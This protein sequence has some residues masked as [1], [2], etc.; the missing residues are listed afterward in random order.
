MRKSLVL[1][2]SLIL[3]VFLLATFVACTDNTPNRFTLELVDKDV[4]YFEFTLGEIDWDQI[5]FYIYDNE[6]NEIYAQHTATE[7]MVAEEDRDKLYFA[8]TKTIKLIYQGAELFVTL[9]LNSPVY[10]R[11]YNVLFNAGEGVFANYEGTPNVLSVKEDILETIPIPVR[12]GYEFLGWF[13]DPTGLSGTKII[14]PYTLKRNL[15]LYAKWSD[16]RRYSV[17]Y[18]VYED[19][20]RKEELEQ[21]TNV[22]HG[23]ELSLVKHT[24]KVGYIFDCY[25][26]LNLDDPS[27]DI[28]TIKYDAN[29]DDFTHVV[30]N[31]LQIRLRYATRMISLTYICDA[32]EENE[33]IGDVIVVAD[34][35]RVQVPYNTIL[36][37]DI[38][39][40][41]TLPDKEGHTGI[42]IDNETSA[43]PVY[44]RATRD[45]LVKAVYTPIKYNMYFYDEND[46]LIPN[47][48][49]IVSYNETIDK[50]PD[51]PEK[52]GHDGVWMVINRDYNLNVPNGQ[53][54]Q[55]PLKDIMMK[56]DVKVYARYTPKS[57]NVTF[58]FKM[59][60]MLQEVTE[61]FVYR[62]GDIIESPIDLTINRVIDNVEYA[63]YD[64]KYYE[65]VW[66][67]SPIRVKEKLVGFPYDVIDTVNFYYEVI[68]RPYTVEFK[69]PDFDYLK[70]V[71]FNQAPVYVNPGDNVVP[72]QI[73]MEGYEVTGWYYTAE[74]P[75]YDETVTYSEGDF[76]YYNGHYYSA[77]QSSTGIKPLSPDD[78]ANDLYWL[79]GGQSF[80]FYLEDYPNGIPIDDFHEYNQDSYYDRA[81]YAIVDVKKFSVTFNNLNITQGDDGYVYEYN[82][83]GEP[84]MVD[85]AT[86]GISAPTTLVLP[87]YPDGVESRFTF[88][89]W[90]T[91]S[92]FVTLPIDLETY[93]ITKDLVLYAKWSDELVGTDGLIYAPNDPENI[94]SYTIVGF[95]TN[96]AEYSHLVLRIPAYHNGKPVVA[97]ENNAFASFDK[98]LYIDEIIIPATVNSIGDSV[99]TAC[100]KVDKITLDENNTAFMIDNDGVLYSLDGQILYSAI[101][102]KSKSYSIAN[103]VKTI[104]GGA[105]A[106]LNNLETITIEENSSLTTIGEYAFD[107]C[108]SLKAIVIPNS[109]ESIGKYAFR[110]NYSLRNVDIDVVNS[111]LLQVGEGAFADSLDALNTIH[112]TQ[113]NPEYVLLGRVLIA[114][115][116]D[117][118]ELTLNDNIVAIADGAFNR[119]ITDSNASNYQ[120]NKL[121]V[122]ENS[123]LSY[124]GHEVFFSCANLNTIILLST[125]FVEIESD[126]FDGISLSSKLYVSESLLDV[127]KANDNYLIF[128]V[129]NIHIHS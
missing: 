113:G 128:G 109:L 46:V 39:P 74:A 23:T 126:S 12:E 86:V 67:S 129:D 14:T 49:R 26:I 11:E 76:V 88:E 79:V 36:Q 17:S 92:E 117:A 68:R 45:M 29:S 93:K 10:V 101:A 84:I 70:D 4:E 106:N 41:P 20:R 90:Y 95:E 44:N 75:L 61:T 42:W 123:N 102:L 18:F 53:L 27:A 51:V 80:G 111:N 21:V 81:F 56:E 78:N 33:N 91:E 118:V 114:Y 35:Y 40:I 82:V 22:E 77:Q 89:G 58:N 112:D 57:F 1:L 125:N 48:T 98:T 115:L 97:I 47:A 55:Y 31:N 64:G 2:I 73:I 87:S 32:W 122:T 120:L 121:I 59:D 5:S 28:V 38:L 19:D 62:Y 71:S 104:K 100:N 119:H 83:V 116:G 105:F 34:T 50:E 66:Y 8:G 103:A 6:T 96:L 94:T 108:I 9:K 3:V 99:F 72:P 85:Y 30:C 15:T 127:Y 60:G 124:I 63:G 24:E 54:I 7:S 110:S 25:E 16:Q 37:K 52:T 69:L 107:G 65:I 43:E 13:E